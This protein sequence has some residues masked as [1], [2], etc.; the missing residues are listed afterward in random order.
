L[1]SQDSQNS[2]QPTGI[3][4]KSLPPGTEFLDTETGGQKSA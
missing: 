4:V 1:A 3:G 2:R